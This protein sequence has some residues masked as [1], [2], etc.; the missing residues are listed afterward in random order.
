[1]FS[2]E[3]GSRPE[4]RMTTA[5]VEAALSI[6]SAGMKITGDVETL[7]VLKVDGEINGSV[8]GAR[9]VLLGRGGAVRGNIVAGEVVIGG[10]VEGSVTAAERLELQASATVSGDIETRSIVVL[11][12]ARINGLV[13]M[14]E[15]I[16]VRSEPLR[17]ARA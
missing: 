3:V 1:M 2:K 5:P 13:R 17:I 12:G 4:A 11:E 10:H 7:G 14:T 8:T 16:A 15:A 6:I 9:Q